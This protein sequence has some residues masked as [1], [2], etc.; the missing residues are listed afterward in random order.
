M[1]D[2]RCVQ[3]HTITGWTG[4][5]RDILCLEGRSLQ[6]RVTDRTDTHKNLI[7]FNAFQNRNTYQFP[8]KIADG[9]LIPE[10][11]KRNRAV[12]APGDD[13]FLFFSPKGCNDIFYSAVPQTTAGHTFPFF[14]AGAAVYFHDFAHL[15]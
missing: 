5:M 4:Y 3:C 13:L 8:A 9:N 6:L 10:I 1:S 12:L 14:P 11:I 7:V 15:L 2:S